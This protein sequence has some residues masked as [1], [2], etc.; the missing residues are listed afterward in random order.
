LFGVDLVV[1]SWPSPVGDG[2]T[3]VS[4][5]Y[6]VDSKGSS[7]E[8]VIIT[9]PIPMYSLLLSKTNSRPGSIP[10]INEIDG[11]YQVTAAGFEWRPPVDEND[12]GRLEFNVAGDDAEGFFPVEVRYRTA[13]TFCTVDVLSTFISFTKIIGHRCQIGGYA[14]GCSVWK[15]Y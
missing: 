6:E 1:N 7:L 12:N 3:D 5:E 9:I 2:S 11:D 15:Q 4:I 14:T 8:D 13:K 10:N